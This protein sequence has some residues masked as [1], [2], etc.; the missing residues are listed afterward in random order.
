MANIDFPSGLRP[1][2]NRNGSNPEVRVMNCVATVIY[3]GALAFLSS[4]G[5]VGMCS[6][7]V[8]TSVLKRDIVGV[9]AEGRAAGADGAEGVTNLIRVYT[10]PEQLYVIQTDD[11]TV[12]AVTDAI[13]RNFTPLAVN[14]GNSTTLRSICEIDGNTGAVSAPRAVAQTLQCVGVQKG[15]EIDALPLSSSWTKL[16]VKIVP[17]AHIYRN[18]L[19]V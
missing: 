4:T 17:S 10:D 9:F 14:S 6:S 18:N 11:D 1:L 8:I 2:I 13:G 16:I 5:L 15:P 12:S 3:E 7:S 19:G